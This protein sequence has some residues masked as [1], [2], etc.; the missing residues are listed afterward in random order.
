MTCSDLIK[1]NAIPP[2]ILDKCM[3]T[4]LS[5]SVAAFIKK[6]TL[7]KCVLVPTYEIYL[8]TQYNRNNYNLTN[9]CSVE[10]NV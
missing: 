4:Y 1:K 10:K 9:V 5:V 7:I 3:S 8:G 6:Y 2:I